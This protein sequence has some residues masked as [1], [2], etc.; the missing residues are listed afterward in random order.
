MKNSN[1]LQEIIPFIN[2]NFKAPISG[3]AMQTLA[4]FGQQ[5]S[6]SSEN[7]AIVLPLKEREKARKENGESWRGL[8][9]NNTPTHWPQQRVSI[10]T[11]RRLI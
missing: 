4:H 7:V 5:W 2:H 3:R 8:D 9:E 6:P 11:R 10:Q 1:I